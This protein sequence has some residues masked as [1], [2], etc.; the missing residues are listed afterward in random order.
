MWERSADLRI[1]DAVFG[2]FPGHVP[3]RWTLRVLLASPPL[4]FHVT[5]TYFVVAH[6][7]LR[8]VRHDRVRDV[9]RCLFLVPEDDWSAAGRAAGQTAFLADHSSDFT[10]RSWPSTGSATWGCRVATPTICPATGSSPERG[11]DGR[12][13][14]PRSVDAAVRGTCSRAGVTA[15]SSPSTIRGVTA[16]RWSG[17]P[18]AHRRGTTSPSC[19]DP[20]R[21]ARLRIA[22][23][24]HEASDARRTPMSAT[25]RS[26]T[27]SGPSSPDRTDR[28]ARQCWRVKSRPINLS[29][30]APSPAAAYRRD[31]PVCIGHLRTRSREEAMS[32]RSAKAVSRP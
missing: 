1:A 5:D 20:P 12:R 13:I 23:P 15:R 8:A 2:R 32:R 26:T 9:R 19:R 21:A 3:A 4:N 29:L 30:L 6:F 14:H 24:P 7:P 17:R 22:L 11:L 18:V 10:P 31:R 16:T 25:S 27:L 28:Q